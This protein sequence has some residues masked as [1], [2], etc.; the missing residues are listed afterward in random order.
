MTRCFTPPGCFGVFFSKIHMLPAEIMHLLGN[1]RLNSLLIALPLPYFHCPC[2]FFSTLP[3][4]FL[5]DIV[6]YVLSL[7]P[8]FSLDM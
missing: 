7:L 1:F 5:L 4:L 6:L 8:Q 2:P 3:S